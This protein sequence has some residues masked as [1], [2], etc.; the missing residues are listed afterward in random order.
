MIISLARSEY[1]SKQIEKYIETLEVENALIAAENDDLESQFEYFSSVQYQERIAKQNL[2]KV[3]PGEKVLVIPDDVEL[4]EVESFEEN[5]ILEKERQYA[6]LPNW[7]KWTSYFF[8][9][10]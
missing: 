4:S 5:L 1:N 2:G 10:Y 6:K 7:Q 9:R 8:R 3:N